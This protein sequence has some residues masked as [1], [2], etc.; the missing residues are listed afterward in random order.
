MNDVASQ[1]LEDAGLLDATRLMTPPSGGSGARDVST[2]GAEDASGM[3]RAAV[4][5]A[6]RAPMHGALA[7][8]QL[9]Q[10]EAGQHRIIV[11][12]KAQ[13]YS[14]REI[15]RMTGWSD[16]MVSNTLRQPW[17]RELLLQLVSEAGATGVMNLLASEQVPSILKLV[18]VRD[19]DDAKGSEV[20]AACNSLLDRFMGKPVQRVESDV[21]TRVEPTTVEDLEREL[22]TA[23]GEE[24]R[25]KAN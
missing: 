1:A 11:T 22:A 12:L 16:F 6:L 10:K 2:N 5:E 20:I 14:N 4:C 15:A 25:L 9:L 24:G 19:S 13:G 8:S 17:A 21:T 18:E 23:R 7:P 3:E